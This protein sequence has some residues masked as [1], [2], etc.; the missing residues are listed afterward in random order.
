MPS[1][2]RPRMATEILRRQH[3]HIEQ[4]LA[5]LEAQADDCTSEF[6]LLAVE[7]TAHLVS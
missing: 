2:V 5:L 1:D 4:E 3:R 7:L 6:S